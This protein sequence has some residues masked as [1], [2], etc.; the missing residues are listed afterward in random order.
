MPTYDYVV[1]EIGDP[2]LR[3]QF[4]PHLRASLCETRDRLNLDADLDTIRRARATA[5]LIRESV[6]A[7]VHPHA[8]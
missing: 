6:R 3:Q 5:H 8:R 7:V 2:A 4:A 1:Y